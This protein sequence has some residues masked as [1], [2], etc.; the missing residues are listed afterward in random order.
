MKA[1][2]SWL[3]QSG[4][5]SNADVKRDQTTVR[6]TVLLIQYTNEDGPGLLLTLFKEFG[7]RPVVINLSHDRTA[8]YNPHDFSAV[9]AFGGPDS[10]NDAS[11]K[12]NVELSLVRTAL[13][14]GVPFLGI[15]LGLQVATK[16][17]GGK[18][19]TARVKEE[20]FYDSSGKPYLVSLTEQATL[21]LGERDP[22]LV[23]VPNQFPTFEGHHETIELTGHMKLLATGNHCRNQIV[24]FSNTAYGLQ[25]H[26][27]LE[28]SMLR[29]WIATDPALRRVGETKLLSD[30][31][32]NQD[33]YSRIGLT[34]L[35]NFL[36]IAGIGPP[37]PNNHVYFGA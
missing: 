33:E 34:I 3:L 4:S 30:Y 14:A 31:N 27:E 9:I 35:G 23:D 6:K 32:A 28:P 26:I 24:K 2:I 17:L 11:P 21:D 37:P 16:I 7:I 10:A 8:T 29:E 1:S 20:G 5:A 22:L 18:V 25:P 36:R 15:C 12:M 13:D 19:I